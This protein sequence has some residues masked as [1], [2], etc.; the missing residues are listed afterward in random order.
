MAEDEALVELETDKVTVEVPSPVSGTLVEIL[1][2]V[3][4]EVNPDEV[5]AKVRLTERAP[6]AAG[7]ASSLRSAR[8]RACS[9]VGAPTCGPVPF[10]E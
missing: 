8:S 5:L 10:A 9:S 7:S 4:A 3:D 2:Q 1:K 6:A